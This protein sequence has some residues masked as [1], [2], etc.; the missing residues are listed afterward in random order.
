MVAAFHRLK[1]VA[2][3]G[4][5]FGI[6]RQAAHRLLKTQGID[7]SHVAEKKPAPPL[8]REEQFWSRVDRSGGPD[9]C[10][11]L[12]LRLRK[13]GY[14][15]VTYRTVIW[16]AHRLA[17]FLTYGSLPTEPLLMHKCGIRCC[18]NPRH[19]RPGTQEENGADRR[20]HQI[21]GRGPHAVAELC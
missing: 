16:R 7:T 2:A 1:N 14:G 18:C 3:V 8:T 10:W 15:T 19:L 4:R 12:L 9:S 6:T 20:A 5:E 21:I 17:W 11:P 13:D